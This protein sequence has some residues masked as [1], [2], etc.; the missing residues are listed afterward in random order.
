MIDSCRTVHYVQMYNAPV[1]ILP[2]PRDN[3][4]CLKSHPWACLVHQIPGCKNHK[5]VKFLPV[6]N[7]LLSNAL[8][9]QNIDRCIIIM[10]IWCCRLSEV[11]RG[12]R[13]ASWTRPSPS[14]NASSPRTGNR[15][16][17]SWPPRSRPGTYWLVGIKIVTLFLVILNLHSC[18]SK[19]KLI[20]FLQALW[21]F[22]QIRQTV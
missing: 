13:W 19:P 18:K 17:R 14:W 5:F 8:G 22:R 3:H 21:V 9:G 11:R 4:F 12:R 2:H 15:W 10:R 20:F 1:I 7:G 16:T 6:R